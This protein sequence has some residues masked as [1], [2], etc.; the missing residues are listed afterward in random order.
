MCISLGGVAGGPYI[1][2]PPPCH[3]GLLQKPSLL[4]I[5]DQERDADKHAQYSGKSCHS[6]LLA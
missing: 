3:N 4:W 2:I 5:V 1:S 6:K